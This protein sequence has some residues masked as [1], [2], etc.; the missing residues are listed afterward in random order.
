MPRDG[1]EALA[2]FDYSRDG[3]IN[4]SDYIFDWLRVWKA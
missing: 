1:F 2:D 4:A 3:V